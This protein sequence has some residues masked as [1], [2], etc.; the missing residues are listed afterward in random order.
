MSNSIRRLLRCEHCLRHR[1]S[2]EVAADAV[3]SETE[4][5]YP[6]LTDAVFLNPFRLGELSEN[7]PVPCNNGK[8]P[9]NSWKICLIR[10]SSRPDRPTL[11]VNCLTS[12][13]T[14]FSLHLWRCASTVIPHKTLA[15]C[16]KPLLLRPHHPPIQTKFI[17]VPRRKGQSV[18]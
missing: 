7:F 1:S 12:R 4:E 3:A 14:N 8:I 5:Q 16:T 15:V 18:A 9:H 2:K 13:Y 6:T 11:V 10:N 17:F